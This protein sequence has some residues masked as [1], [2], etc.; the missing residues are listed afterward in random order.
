MLRTKVGEAHAALEKA[1]NALAG[2]RILQASEQQAIQRR[3]AALRAE[4]AFVSTRE[5][6]AQELYRRVRGELEEL[7][8]GVDGRS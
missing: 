4:V 1:R 5:R 8:I 7:R 3:L 2:F 6:E